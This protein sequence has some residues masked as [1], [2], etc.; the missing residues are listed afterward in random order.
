MSIPAVAYARVSTE[1]QAEDEL[2]ITAQL[3]EIRRFAETRGYQVVE[4]FI[5]AG[6]TGRTEDRPEFSRLRKIISS[7]KAEF[8]AVI[9]WRSNRFARSARIAQGFRFLLEQKNIRLFSVTE[10]EM[11]GSVGVLMN[12]ILD[13]F[14]EF[15]SAQLAEDVFR[16]MVAT[17]KAGYAVGGTAPFGYKKVPVVLDSG[18]I[19]K[20]LEPVPE[21]AAIVREIYQ[22]YIEGMGLYQIA[23]ALNARGIQTP[24]GKEW[25]QTTVYQMLHK[26]RQCYLGNMLFNR[27]KTVVKKHVGKKPEE[28]WILTENTH[29]PIITREM[30]EAVERRHK[31]VPRPRFQAQTPHGR[32]LLNGLIFCGLCGRRYGGVKAYSGK[33]E[34][35]VINWYYACSTKKTSTKVDTSQLCTNAYVRQ[36]FIEEAVLS[37]I[38]KS[39]CDPEALRT[40]LQEMQ[41]ELYQGEEDKTERAKQLKTERAE[42]EKRRDNLLDAVEQGV[43]PLADLAERLEKAKKRLKEIDLLLGDLQ[44]SNMPQEAPDFDL[45]GI[46]AKISTLLED[47]ERRREVYI[48]FVD[49]IDV[50]PEQVK[51]RLRIPPDSSG[52]GEEDENSVPL[53]PGPKK[54]GEIGNTGNLH[55]V[56]NS[57]REAREIS[58]GLNVAPPP[59]IETVLA[60]WCAARKGLAL[61]D[62]SGR[63]AV[64]RTSSTS[65]ISSSERGGR[66]PFIARASSVLPDPGE[67]VNSRL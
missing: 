26:N 23:K 20:K 54:K 5:D 42:L 39:F 43:L 67:P 9:V 44:T 25:A 51:I 11:N 33:R 36:E 21:Q 37:E 63:P 6:I 64:L 19:K 14:N 18:G 65:I 32:N 66:M 12:G 45:G 59:Q 29:E 46:S 57:P 1:S 35:N 47:P 40:V 48:A 30:A 13:A 62:S 2:P 3:D 58:P 50:Y 15:Y 52:D 16:G 55:Y 31:D 22:L 7:G 27:T 61:P 28:E 8:K 49:R 10:P 53:K 41:A 60:V 56:N 34:N 38:R 4:E 24:R 17:A